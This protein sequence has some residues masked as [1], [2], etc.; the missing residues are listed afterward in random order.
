MSQPGLI[1]RRHVFYVEGYDPQGANGYYPLFRREFERFKRLWSL[2][3][4]ISEPEIDPRAHATRWTVETESPNWRVDVTYE[5][6]DWGDIVGRDFKRS[7]L[8]S[9]PRVLVWLTSYLVT[10]ALFRIFWRS[11]RFAM[12]V[13]GSF[14]V[15]AIWVMIAAAGGR[16]V[17]RILSETLAVAPALAIPAGVISA[18]LIFVAL[19]KIADRIYIAH[20]INAW[21]FLYDYLRGLRPDFEQRMDEFAARLIA[22]VRAGKADEI[23]IV[24][25]SGGTFSAPLMV[26]KAL[27][28][29]PE[30]GRRGTRIVLVTLGTVIPLVTAHPRAKRFR[31]IL[32]RLAHETGV[33][34]VDF[35]SR[36]DSLNFF[37]AD[38]TIDSGIG[39]YPPAKNPV[40]F[41][42]NLRALLLPETFKKF[43]WDFFRVHFQFIMANDRP[44]R[45]DYYLFLCG[46]IPLMFWPGH[47]FP[48]DEVF[49]PDGALLRNVSA[50]QS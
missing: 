16:F 13:I 48:T 44:A 22:A 4:S 25:H 8:W 37:V 26:A 9:L 34:W 6:L 28:I 15:L 32:V 42:V 31:D 47:R 20:L 24:G 40:I 2:R 35:Q 3:G 17:W 19:Q 11:W 10:G 49:G 12:F 23:L 38:P 27:A 45:Y 14:V 5:F 41:H 46:P 29:D 39:V 21:L 43:R 50:L 36:Q 18:F 33:R 1:R 7:M 30:L